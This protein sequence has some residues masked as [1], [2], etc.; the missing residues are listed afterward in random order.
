MF[1]SRMS[2]FGFSSQLLTLSCFGL[3]AAGGVMLTGCG[4]E[5][6]GPQEESKKE[7][8]LQM[9][10]AQVDQVTKLGGRSA[11][12]QF[13]VARMKI[14]NVSNQPISMDP[15]SFALEFITDKE[16]ERYTQSYEKNISNDFGATYG[17][18]NKA[19]L[20]DWTTDINPRIE[21]ERFFVFMVP[22]DAKA[23]EYQIVYTDP[24][25]TANKINVPLVTAGTTVV[26]DHRSEFSSSTHQPNTEQ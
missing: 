7:E 4:G 24:N 16:K 14:K 21:M 15:A 26:N 11:E 8:P 25:N 19:K 6:G 13:L 2:G 20:M 9:Q 23:D 1:K 5:S 22:S 3:L 18:E 17:D 12:G 10:V